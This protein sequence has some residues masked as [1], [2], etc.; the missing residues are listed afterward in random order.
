MPIRLSVPTSPSLRQYAENPVD[1]PEWGD[2][3]FAEARER[4]VPCAPQ[5]EPSRPVRVVRPSSVHLGSG[6]AVARGLLPCH[7]GER[8]ELGREMVRCRG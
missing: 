6:G 7:A 3:A 8:G 1:W 4:D 5:A 2:E